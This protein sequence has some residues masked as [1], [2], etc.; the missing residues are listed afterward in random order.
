MPPAHPPQPGRATHSQH[1]DNAYELAFHGVSHNACNA[2]ELTV[3][4]VCLE[5][6]EC[7]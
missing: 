3:G 6:R 5:N 4:G 1:A 7:L 2:Y